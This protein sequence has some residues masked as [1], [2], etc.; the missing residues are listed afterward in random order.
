ML[1]LT[2]LKKAITAFD[3]LLAVATNKAF[4][5]TLDPVPRKGIQA[6]VIQHFEFTYELCWKFIRRWLR[7]NLGSSNVDGLSRKDLYRV[8][9]ENR[10][11]DDVKAWWGFHEA[12]NL[13]SHTYDE[14]TSEE[15]FQAALRF[16]D[17]AR[18]L[19]DA[20]EERND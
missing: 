1:D 5:D 9:A 12:R 13:T 11:I 8:A 16:K 10:L 20:L 2:S 17:Y 3:D 7:Q 18:A 4:M 15:V 19:L 6:G 14:E